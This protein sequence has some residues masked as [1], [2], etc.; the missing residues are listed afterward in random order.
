MLFCLC[1]SRNWSAELIVAVPHRSVNAPARDDE[2]VKAGNIIR[3]G[4]S[5]RQG[6]SPFATARNGILAIFAAGLSG[7]VPTP[8]SRE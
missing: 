5:F 3:F 8:R 7:H 6:F 2:R 4:R 1:L